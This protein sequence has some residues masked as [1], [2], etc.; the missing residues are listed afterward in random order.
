MNL[1]YIVGRG[2]S[3]TTMLDISLG[4]A[5]GMRSTGEMVSGLSRYPE[6]ECS[7]GKKV[8]CCDHWSLAFSEVKSKISLEE[9]SYKISNMAKIFAIWR[10]PGIF[11]SRRF[12]S[13]LLLERDFLTQLSSSYN[14]VIDS[15]K[16]LCRGLFLALGPSKAKW[17][18]VIRDPR[19][20]AQ[21]A[22]NRVSRG[23][24]IKVNRKIFYFKKSALPLLDIIMILSWAVWT[25]LTF[26]LGK[27][28]LGNKYM[29]ISYD[30]FVSDPVFYSKIIS[31]KMYLNLSYETIEKRLEEVEVEHIV[32]G[33]RMAQNKRFT[34]N[35]KENRSDIHIFI[36]YGS[37]LFAMPIYWLVRSFSIRKGGC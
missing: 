26:M 37:I 1:I 32:G 21:S 5:L 16:E 22:R 13:L 25:V 11:F 2:H 31:D 8:Q 4:N 19:E 34:I 33:N 10:I 6:Q 36:R 18:H 12:K 7:C 29:V 3:G 15:S 20:V 9:Y 17:L 24:P 30:G 27:A 35:K 23:V 14:G 28:F